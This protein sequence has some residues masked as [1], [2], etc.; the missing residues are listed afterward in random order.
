MP[1]RDDLHTILIIGSGPIV[2]GQACEFDYSG[3][4]AVRALKEEGYRVALVNPNPATVMT[5]PGI[6]D[7]IYLDPLTV[8]YL[9]DII[10]RERPDGILATMGGQ[11]ALNLAIELAD[12]GVLERFGVEMLG[13]NREAI[14]IAEN[15][16]EFKKM[17]A[18]IGLESPVSTLCHSLDDAIQFTEK[19]GYPVVIRPSF[20]LGGRGGNIASDRD[21]LERYMPVALAMSPSHSALIEESLIG[22]QEFELEAMRDRNDNAVIVCS[23]ENVDPMGVHTGDSITV[24][25][26]QTL[27]DRDYQT[28]RS[29]AIEILR[30]VGVDCGG[31]N[32]QF[33]RQA[34]TGRL[35]VIEMNPRV[36]RSSAL[37]SKAT[38]FPI[39]RCSA[40]LA[41]GFTLDEITNEITG[42][43]VSCFEPAL[44]YCA[45]KTP[46]FELEKF[47]EDPSSL[48]TQMKSVGE[49][50][51]IGRDYLEALNKSIRACEM[52][53]DGLRPLRRDRSD[54]PHSDER[55]LAMIRDRHPRRLFAAYTLLSQSGGAAIERIERASGYHRWFLEQMLRLI[56][57]ERRIGSVASERDMPFS[58]LMEAKRAGMSD[59]R[60]AELLLAGKSDRDPGASHGEDASVSPDDGSVALSRG[61]SA[62]DRRR[63]A[64]MI[65]EIRRQK[66]INPAYHFVDTCAG[67][68][69]A[70]TPYFYSSYGERD[71][72]EPLGEEAVIIIGSGPNRV[73][74]GLEFDCCCALCSLAYRALGRKTVLINSNPETVS[75]DFNVSDRL[76]LEPITAEDV[77]GIMRKEGAKEAVVQLGG[78]TALNIADR[79]AEHGAR[80]VGTPIDRIHDAENRALFNR[81][82]SALGLLQPKSAGASTAEEARSFAASIGYPALL[83]PSY[84][85]GGR[86]MAI[87]YSDK[88]LDRYLLQVGHFSKREPLLVDQFIE[89]AFEYDLDAISDGNSVYIAGVMEHIEAAGIH[90]GDSACVFPAYK[91]EQSVMD[92]MREAAVSIARSF[93]IVGFLNIQFAV[94]DGKVYVLEVNPRASRSVPYISKCIGVNLVAAAVKIWQGIDLRQQGLVDERGVGEGKS[95]VGWAV[96]EAV[97]SFDRFAAIDPLLGPEMRSTGES[98]G[99]GRSFGEAFAK[100]TIAAGNELPSSGAVYLSLND[101][102]KETIAPV[103]RQLSEL[104]FSLF[105]SRGTANFL[106]RIGLDAKSVPKIHEESPNIGDLLRDGKIHLVINTPLGSSSQHDDSDFRIETLRCR[107]PY[108]TTTSA[109]EAAVEAIAA[110]RSGSVAAVPLP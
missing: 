58:L 69:D 8:P 50:L 101:A 26:I 88:E 61:S 83:R 102:D 91:Y 77:A 53:Y 92:R 23:I 75:T 11:T 42:K 99:I 104:G 66:N 22:W 110:L 39:A 3:N 45:V 5:A 7:A 1:R 82:I 74:Q 105:A 9:T 49:S 30:A 76:Y 52:G 16:G 20:T 10:Q 107:I 97:F 73:G 60:I 2:I 93:G 48:G 40:K 38:G 37:A 25:P 95:V 24:A 41:V 57:I 15:R 54:V 27:N 86:R 96:K 71:E 81:A 32:V 64:R 70:D 98:I 19:S 14:N 100:A 36:S 17:I 6:A 4:Q 94:K 44:D 80:V 33:A 18:S 89:D 84:V 28:M 43:T 59:L 79:L 46:Y 63:S 13:A 85:L 106:R 103:A 21:E 78:Q 31:S 55:L 108:T 87:V 29:A 35:L 68:F 12:C 62:S 56:D 51:A 72:G 90:S 47:P 67:E 65:G 34:S 109:A